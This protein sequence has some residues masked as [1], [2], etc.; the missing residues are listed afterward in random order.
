MFSDGLKHVRSQTVNSQSSFEGSQSG[1]LLS[2][3][4]DSGDRLR[5]QT[6]ASSLRGADTE[7]VMEKLRM[8]F[9]AYGLGG[10]AK[11]QSSKDLSFSE[12]LSKRNSMHKNVKSMGRQSSLSSTD[13]STN[14]I[15]K[16]SIRGGASIVLSDEKKMA[17]QLRTYLKLSRSMGPIFVFSGKKRENIF[18]AIKIYHKNENIALLSVSCLELLAEKTEDK[19]VFSEIMKNFGNLAA[20][21]GTHVTNVEFSRNFLSL[22]VHIIKKDK[23]AMPQLDDPAYLETFRQIKDEHPSDPDIQDLFMI[24]S[25]NL[26]MQKQGIDSSFNTP[27]ASHEKGD[28]DSALDKLRRRIQAALPNAKLAL[29]SPDSQSTAYEH[30]S[31]LP[32]S[33]PPRR[34]STEI[35]ERDSVT[36]IGRT[37]TELDAQALDEWAADDLID[38]FEGEGDLVTWDDEGDG[39][40]AK[41]G[42]SRE[43]PRQS[44]VRTY[45]ARRLKELQ[46]QNAQREQSVIAHKQALSKVNE[47]Y[48]KIQNEYQADKTIYASFFTSMQET[49]KK[50]KEEIAKLKNENDIIKTAEADLSEQASKLLREMETVQGEMNE[51]KKQFENMKAMVTQQMNE[52][53]GHYVGVRQ[54]LEDAKAQLSK[55]QEGLLETENKLVATQKEQE[56]KVEEY[57]DLQT[58]YQSKQKEFEES[59][60]KAANLENRYNTI[61]SDFSTKIATNNQELAKGQ[62]DIR[63][64]HQMH[65]TFKAQL[66]KLKMENTAMK[67][68]IHALQSSNTEGNR[69]DKQLKQLN[70]ENTDLKA[71]LNDLIK[72]SAGGEKLRKLQDRNEK[73][74]KEKSELMQMTEMLLARTESHKV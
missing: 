66:M 44:K 9:Q 26:G 67:K 6:S 45:T 3:S 19:A 21:V 68:S 22:V 39:I 52:A 64:A 56:K 20:L 38:N 57:N 70:K 49:E 14:L 60:M 8:R 50:F 65:G 31:I 7:N 54:R 16:S 46:F 28:K 2:G 25:D 4:E 72:K 35:M 17:T 63:L 23:A 1:N 59:R 43:T 37:Q 29:T 32:S 62:S 33:T 18:Y 69:L 11:Q 61:R 53:K 12:Q 58:T 34:K 74:K 36:L 41:S 10:A 5:T 40:N 30:S 47:D 42:K 27:R 71:R 51:K 55:I 48:E 24:L 15:S 73:L 13:M